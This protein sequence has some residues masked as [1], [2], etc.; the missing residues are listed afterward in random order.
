MNRGRS[1]IIYSFGA[2][3]LYVPVKMK[4]YFFINSSPSVG[5]RL[6]NWITVFNFKKKE[7]QPTFQIY[8]EPVELSSF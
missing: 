4:P 1:G 7:T 2:T 6:K 5:P 3:H 8:I